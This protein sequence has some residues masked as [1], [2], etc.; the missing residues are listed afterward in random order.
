MIVGRETNGWGE[1]SRLDWLNSDAH[2]AILKIRE[3]YRRFK[4]GRC[5]R[6][7][8]NKLAWKFSQGLSI[9]PGCEPRAN[10]ILTNLL[11]LDEQGARPDNDVINIL[12][13]L[14]SLLAAEIEICAPDATIFFTGPDSDKDIARAM[15]GVRFR[16]VEG[17]DFRALVKLES[18]QLPEC[19]YRTYHPGFLIF[20]R[21]HHIFRELLQIV[22]AHFGLPTIDPDFEIT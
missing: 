13:D 11:K 12:F 21:N 6:K 8:F 7:P 1:P 4:L 3:E 5:Y 18:P 22:R 9:D 10:F 19:T 14:F 17:Y 15:P 20:P 16:T 2:E